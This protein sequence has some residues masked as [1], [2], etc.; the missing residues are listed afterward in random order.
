M[1]LN[2]IPEDFIWG[3]ATAAYQIEGA[4]NEDGKGK[5]IWDSF[6]SVPANI[7]N[8]DNGNI[9]CDH[10][11]RYREDIGLM[12]AIGIKAYR[13]SLSWPR[14]IPDGTG[15]VNQKGLAFYHKLIDCLLE[16]DIEPWITLYHWDLPQALQDR[17][18]WQDRETA[19]AFAEFA[20]LCFREFGGKVK[21]W[22]TLNE[23]MVVAFVGHLWGFHAPGI[24]DEA[25]L[26]AVFH[27]LNLAHGLAVQE[28]RKSGIKGKIGITLNAEINRPATLREEDIRATEAHIDYTTGV[29]L[30]P[31]YRKEYPASIKRNF[32]GYV[33][34]VQ[35]GDMDIC[36]AGTD[37]MGINY[38]YQKPVAFDQNAPDKSRFETTSYEKTEMGWDIYPSGLYYAFQWFARNFPEIPEYYVTENGMACPDVRG[39]DGIVHDR[40]RIEYLRRHFAVCEKAVCEGFPLKGY[41]LWSFMDNFEWAHGFAMRFGLVHMDYKTL[42]RTPKDSYYYYRDVI[43]GN[44]LFDR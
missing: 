14:I 33:F 34:P 40:D 19:Y 32:P 17:G 31:Q 29:F 15:K 23:P 28:F 6:S 3:A 20:G 1:A 27:H 38:Y 7:H 26:P 30:G 24:K 42:K 18:G 11:H 5:S 37:F 10:Y 16:H 4:W 2:K 25:A 35:A 8:G 13:F 39:E 43:T 12:A 9:A 22:I 44:I 21:N 41:F 36:A